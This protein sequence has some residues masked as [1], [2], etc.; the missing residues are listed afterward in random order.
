LYVPVVALASGPWPKL[1]KLGGVVP[2]L[3]AAL[4]ALCALP[5]RGDLNNPRD[6]PWP[7]FI[8]DTITD[9]R[10]AMPPRE[11]KVVIVSCYKSLFELGPV[12]S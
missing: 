6:R 9:M 10:H 5:L 12:L 2:S 11:A 3:A 8:R 7:R 4:M 1:V